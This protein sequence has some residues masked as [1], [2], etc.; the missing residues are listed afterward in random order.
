MLCF[1]LTWSCLLILMGLCL[2]IV[3]LQGWIDHFSQCCN[4]RGTGCC[5]RSPSSSREAF[6]W[7][8]S[9]R[10]ATRYL[11][12]LFQSGI[13]RTRAGPVVS[14][15]GCLVLESFQNFSGCHWHEDLGALSPSTYPQ[16]LL[17]IHFLASH[18]CQVVSAPQLG[19]GGIHIKKL[20]SLLLPYPRVWTTAVKIFYSVN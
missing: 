5:W 16:L 6:T 4:T 9:P 2:P 3:P 10:S 8:V 11:W 17:T 20:P 7:N 1:S 12:S 14:A 19:Q 15:P 13:C 18:S